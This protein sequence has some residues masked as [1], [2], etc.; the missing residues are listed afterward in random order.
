MISV[1][2]ETLKDQWKGQA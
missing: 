1:I 2:Y